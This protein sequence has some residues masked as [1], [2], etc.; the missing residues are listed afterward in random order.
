MLNHPSLV[1]DWA[2][3]VGCFVPLFAATFAAC[4]SHACC[5]ALA[6]ASS[7]AVPRCTRV[8]PCSPHL[9]G[10]TVNRLQSNDDSTH[11]SGEPTNI[12]IRGLPQVR[13]EFNGRDTFSADSGRGLNFN[14]ISPELLSRA[15]AYKNQT[16]EMIEGGIAGVVDIAREAEAAHLVHE[17]AR[18]LTLLAGD[19]GDAQHLLEECDGVEIC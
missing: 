9:P 6:T 14:D 17:E 11:P 13:T 8:A 2:L 19:A 18:Q 15:D 7:D 1:A 12:L 16:A 5:S 10:I 4:L 3:A